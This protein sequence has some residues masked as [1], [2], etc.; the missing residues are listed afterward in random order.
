MKLLITKITND[1]IYNYLDL[2]NRVS[3]FNNEIDKKFFKNS[4]Q[5]DFIKTVSKTWFAPFLNILI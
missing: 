2:S 3:H 1:F 5:S 4:Y